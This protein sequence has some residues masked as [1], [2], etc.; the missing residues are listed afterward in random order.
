[1]SGLEISDELVCFQ[2]QEQSWETKVVRLLNQPL[3][4]P[5]KDVLMANSIYKKNRIKKKEK[6]LRTNC[7]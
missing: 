3:N 7:S 6:L 4:H 2:I 5:V 1:M